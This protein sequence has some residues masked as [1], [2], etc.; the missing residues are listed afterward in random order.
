MNAQ[1]GGG[2]EFYIPL[3]LWNPDGCSRLLLLDDGVEGLLGVHLH[4]GVR[5]TN[6][7]QQDGDSAVLSRLP[8]L[9]AHGHRTHRRRAWSEVDGPGHDL[10]HVHDRARG[11]MAEAIGDYGRLSKGSPP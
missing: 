6:L 7:D 3:N 4:R 5:H 10:G 11:V 2:K 8:C 1:W 9:C